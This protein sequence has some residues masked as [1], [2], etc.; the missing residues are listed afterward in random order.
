MALS[1]FGG[2]AISY[3]LPVLWMMSCSPVM[4]ETP[5]HTG[6]DYRER[7]C[8]TGASLMSMNA[9]LHCD[10]H[11]HEIGMYTVSQKCDSDVAL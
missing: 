6:C 7:C 1:S 2:I 4:G 11:V 10:W 9:C 5:K 8:D 3:V